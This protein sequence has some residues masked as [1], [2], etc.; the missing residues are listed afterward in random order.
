MNLQTRFTIM[1][2]T[3]A[4]AFAALPLLLTSC[5]TPPPP[6]L[7]TYYNTDSS[8]L[9]VKSLDSQK[10]QMVLPLAA[11]VE[12]NDSL[13]AKARNLPQHKTAV[14]ILENYTE[15]NLGPQFRDRGTTWFVHLRHL[16]YENIVFLQGNGLAADGLPL[17]ARYH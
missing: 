1:K 15:K 11:Q 14:V 13:L 12:H 3:F 9:V 16:G 8:A 17:L 5:A 7:Q 10:S 6:P 4:L 2:T